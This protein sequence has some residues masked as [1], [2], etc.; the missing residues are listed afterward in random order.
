MRRIAVA[1]MALAIA[2]WPTAT[3]TATGQAQRISL[4]ATT[5]NEAIAPGD[6][7]DRLLRSRE[8]EVR[9]QRQEPLLP[10]RTFQQIDQFHDGIPIWGAGV[11]R[12]LQGSDTV[13]VFGELYVPLSV[14]TVPTI[15]QADAKARIEQIGGDTLGPT[16]QPLLTLVPDQGRLTLA[17][18]GEIATASGA[19]RLFIDASDGSELRREHA[20]RTQLPD[21]SYV[22]HGRGVLGDEKKISTAPES[23]GFIAFDTIRPPAIATFDL[24]QN[25]TR[26]RQ[27]L[28]GLVDLTVSDY[29]STTS[30][31]EWTD[32]ANV[33]AHVYSSLTY[34]YYFKRFGRR[35]LDN[36]DFPIINITHQARRADLATAT[37]TTPW[38]NAFWYD[39]FNAMFY[40]EG[41]GC[42]TTAFG[43]GPQF[44]DYLAGALDVVGHE[45]TH[46]VT[47]FSSGLIYANEA[48][49]LD[50]SFSDIM[51]TSVEFF[52]QA[53]GTGKLKADYLI[54][55]D[56][57]SAASA[58]ALDGIR[59]MENPVLYGDR[60]HYSRRYIGTADNG[61]VH[62][63]SGI[64]NQA[65]YLAVEG[66][67]NRT[68]GLRVQ[69]VGSA[70]REQVEKVFYL[71]FT[72]ML[73]RN[74][75]FALARATT[76]RA[77]Q[78]LYGPSSAAYA[79][80]R[81]AWTAVGVN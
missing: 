61:G 77:A 9:R 12:E 63:N 39:G 28:N 47:S 32:G 58:T 78:D 37:D 4:T 49:A 50:E 11:S 15:G 21:T 52:Y 14:D 75:T 40:G 27:V 44:V 79:A 8:L 23:G 80:V 22:G 13:A 57:I 54:G 25:A 64:S 56:V 3:R 81:D 69:G 68:S 59:S 2:V 60:D 7:I 55:E 10:G 53:P 70:N 43:Y 46:G 19:W 33:D 5:A 17:W 35:G 67:T 74:A 31:N 30:S 65:F 48:G 76:L 1:A 73:P 34:D 72:S 20:A 41:C 16:R 24:R 62:I 6:L 38:F 18:V 71:A 45:L 42:T 36:D 26:A 29:A 66:G 51:G